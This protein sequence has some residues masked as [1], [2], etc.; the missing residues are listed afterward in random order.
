MKS[1]LSNI[2]MRP[3]SDFGANI[4]LFVEQVRKSKKPLMLTD[5]GQTKAVLLDIED[6]ET[7][8]EELEFLK[9]I[10]IAEQQLRDGQYVSDEEAKKRLLGNE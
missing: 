5:N 7:F 3:L 6:Y 1:Q 2:E 10:Q 4:E 9:D 8:V